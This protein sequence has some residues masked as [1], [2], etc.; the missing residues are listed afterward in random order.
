MKIK[1]KCSECVSFDDLID[2][3]PGELAKNAHIVIG[4]NGQCMCGTYGNY[5]IHCQDILGLKFTDFK[6]A[7]I[8][9]S[10]GGAPIKETKE[11]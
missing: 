3:D 8:G 10:F 6:N 11:I 1:P 5:F 4:P 2:L 9:N 7:V